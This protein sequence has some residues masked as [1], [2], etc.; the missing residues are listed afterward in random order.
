MAIFEGTIQE[1]HHHIGPKIRN[2]INTFTSESRKARNDVC[3]HCNKTSNQALHSAH[4]PGK[5][6][7]T[8][9]EKV[10]KDYMITD[11]LVRCNIETVEHEILSEHHPIDETFKFLC[12]TCH[13]KYDNPLRNLLRNLILVK[14]A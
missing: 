9:I 12:P 7:R 5:G 4:V 2:A 6:R 11:A 8:I 1:Y 14:V 10:L 3:E 13:F